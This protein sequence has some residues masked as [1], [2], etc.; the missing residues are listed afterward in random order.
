MSVSVC[1]GCGECWVSY[2]ELSVTLHATPAF[3][4][5]YAVDSYGAGYAGVPSKPITADFALIGLH[6]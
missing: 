6:L 4:L 1:L 5:R 2:G 3:A